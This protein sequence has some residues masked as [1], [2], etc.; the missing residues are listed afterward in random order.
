MNA[1]AKQPVAPPGLRHYGGRG[2]QQLGLALA[3]LPP[4]HHGGN[5]VAFSVVF[6]ITQNL[7]SQ[8]L[9]CSGIA[10]RCHR[11]PGV[12]PGVG[13]SQVKRIIISIYNL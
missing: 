13:Q 8:T 1:V 2:R 7:Q 10:G 6:S 3:G 9:W 12:D 4:R 5:A 11:F